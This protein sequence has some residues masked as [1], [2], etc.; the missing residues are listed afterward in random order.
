MANF[1]MTK[2]KLVNILLLIIT[3]IITTFVVSHIYKHFK[4][5]QIKDANYFS[6]RRTRIY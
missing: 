4:I 1:K 3:I 6:F 2:F 5:K